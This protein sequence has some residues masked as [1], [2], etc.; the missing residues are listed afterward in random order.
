MSAI[1][2]SHSS[3][4][5]DVAR[6]VEERLAAEGHRSV[7]LDFDPDQ[8][9]PA[10]VEWEKVLF[11]KLQAS[12][13]LIVLCSPASMSS[14]WV[15][16]EIAY[17]RAKGKRVFPIEVTECELDARLRGY[18][19]IDATD[20]WEDAFKRLFLGLEE[21]GLTA[22][23]NYD[24]ERPPYPGLTVFEEQDAAV[25]FGRENEI[26][27]VLETLNDMREF[28]GANLAVVLGASGS[29]KSSLIRAGIVPRL[30]RNRRDW[31]VVDPIRPLSDPSGSPFRELAKAWSAAGDARDSPAAIDEVEAALRRRPDPDDERGG[32]SH[33]A[34]RLR[35]AAGRDRAQVVVV[36]DQLEELLSPPPEKE[37][38]VVEFSRVLLGSLR[39][40]GSPLIVLGTLRSDRL[41]E[42]QE[43]VEEVPFKDYPLA[44]FQDAGF[45][46]VIRGPAQLAEIELEEGLIELVLRDTPT[47][48]A[49]PL[50]AYALHE[51]WRNYGDDRR[52]EIAEYEKLGGL[53]A[54]VGRAAE[55]VL[56]AYLEERRM[57]GGRPSSVT[58]V[59]L[60]RTATDEARTPVDHAREAFLR[61]VHI[62]DRGNFIRQPVAWNAL[63][64]FGR[65]LLDR[66]VEARLLISRRDGGPEPSGARVIQVAH[67]ALFRTW[68]RLAEWIEEERLFLHWRARLRADVARWERAKRDDEALL[69]GKL[70]LDAERWIRMLPAP[71]EQSETEFITRSLEARQRR[72]E[73]V[74]RRELERRR[75]RWIGA[76]LAASLLVA[77]GLGLAADS[78]RRQGERL[79]AANRVLAAV[80]AANPSEDPLI[81]ALLAAELSVRRPGEEPAE[82]VTT[83]LGVTGSR[84]PWARLPHA[85]EVTAG[86]LGLDGAHAIT[87]AA[88]GTVTIWALRADSLDAPRVLQAGHDDDVVDI[89]VREDG[90][91]VTAS[92]DG[93]ARVWAADGTPGPVLRAHRAGLWSARFSPDGSS[94]VTASDDHRGLVWELRD[95]TEPIAVLGHT[96]PVRSARFSPDGSLVVTASYDST[97]RV[98]RGWEEGAPVQVVLSGHEDH[99]RT[100]RFSDDGSRVVTASGD[101]TARVWRLSDPGTPRVLTGH[102]RAVWSAE[103]SPDDRWIVTAGQDGTARVWPGDPPLNGPPGAPDPPSVSL[104][105]HSGYLTTALFSPDGRY[106]LTAGQD[107]T[108]RVWASSA[109]GWTPSDTAAVAVLRHGSRSSVRA[110][111]G[112]GGDLILTVSTDRS[113]RVWRSAAPLLSPVV[114]SVPT[115]ALPGP[116]WERDPTLVGRHGA[117]VTALEISPDGQHVAAA[118]ADR[119]VY[120]WSTGE[121]GPPLEL[122]GHRGLVFGL[123]FS[124]DGSR[125]VSASEDDTARVWRDDSK[126]WSGTASAE[127][128]VRLPHEGDVVTAVFG[129]SGD[130]IIT[131]SSDKTA[132]IWTVEG[133][134][135]ATL[136]GHS[137]WV[138]AAV[139]DAAVRVVTWSG[140]GRVLLHEPD[141][142]GV[143]RAD[144]IGTHPE[145]GISAAA[146]SP[147]GRTFVSASR[148]RLLLWDLDR[149]TSR[150]LAGHQIGAKIHTVAYS[151]DGSVFVT[152]SEDGTARIWP[153]APGRAT[154]L[155]GHLGP[156]NTASFNPRG[157]HVVTASDDRSVRV[158]DV[159]T[160]NPEIVIRGHR[161]EVLS[162]RFDPEAGRFVVSA[163]ND[164][165]VRLWSLNFDDLVDHMGGLSTYCFD[166][167]ERQRYLGETDDEAG[168]ATA[169]CRSRRSAGNQRSEQ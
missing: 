83:L 79:N 49:L 51:L 168:R 45:A 103:F 36:I 127:A 156:V 130:R 140:D 4:D 100:A 18:Q 87:G 54:C 142:R 120:V 131:A 76:G 162:A 47:A 122:K 112:A 42:F 61:L 96:G 126:A 132:R 46:Q 102:S 30:K 124:P 129:A 16:A 72:Q 57:N 116:A 28:G 60:E 111:F 169:D 86:A 66:F 165:E 71:L 59:P 43:W 24:P 7:F 137:D 23:L 135:D 136:L 15:F 164:G 69:R 133:I 144:T 114:P 155:S 63:P 56:E 50:L 52:L 21:A 150:E 118:A 78:Q 17:A 153:V 58:S 67:E 119:K 27:D 70:L 81:P 141:R 65:D 143:W 80:N 22:G 94:V 92:R 32:L 37:R 38:E 73:E 123:E 13:A 5:N 2:I 1:F 39:S 158:W 95:P 106:I 64:V 3:R 11:K 33:A 139:P 160:G 25:F 146:S 10:G 62:D 35:Q 55:K 115:V 68:T 167:K 53:E 26:H 82:G 34:D 134:A 104:V 8:G 147:D 44:Q 75:R 107:G 163:S 88:D 121:A 145:G 159:E 14:W 20:D 6:R 149:K 161:S 85:T 128:V 77:A 152:A 89:D 31:V 84:V 151:P 40:T 97:A 101:G 93:T 166:E 91:F 154:V 98:W 90:T 113:A 29:G 109:A 19:V 9:F 41:L 110:G 148:D 48:D 99:V 157:T 138:E 117:K 108:A 12:R 125:V 74:A 105:G